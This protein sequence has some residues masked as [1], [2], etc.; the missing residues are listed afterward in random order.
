MQIV[1]WEIRKRG[2]LGWVFLIVFWTLNAGMALLMALLILRFWTLLAS[3]DIGQP[4][5]PEH[6]AR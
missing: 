1:I 3:A 5:D 2:F 4:G 6:P